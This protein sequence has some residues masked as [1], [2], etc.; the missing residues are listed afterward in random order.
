ML[1]YVTSF[2]NFYWNFRFLCTKSSYCSLLPVLQNT[3]YGRKLK[4]SSL[5][6]WAQFC[7]ET[8]FLHLTS[9]KRAAKISSLILSRFKTAFFSCSVTSQSTCLVWLS[10][11]YCHVITQPSDK[12][13]DLL[14][15][16]LNPFLKIC[17]LSL[18]FNYLWIIRF[19][20]TILQT[21]WFIHL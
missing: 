15:C 4:S 20:N 10:A 17:Y 14:D 13:S 1:K 3:H 21:D 12:S 7:Q 6:A 2:N 8:F 11:M 5:L 19:E 18:F 16:A 9:S